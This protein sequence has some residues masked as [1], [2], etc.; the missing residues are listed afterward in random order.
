MPK[1]VGIRMNDELLEK[2]DKMSKEENLDRSTLV[3]KLVEKGYKLQKKEKAADKYKKGQ[4][5]LSKAAEEAEITIWEMEKF[6]I[7]SGYKSQ[8]SVKDLEREI[9][10]ISREK[11]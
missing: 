9:S 2:L 7:D 1:S 6:L 10:E 4:L 8:Y 11:P 3:R 5:T